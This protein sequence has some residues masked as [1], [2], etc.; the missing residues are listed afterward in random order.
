[1]SEETA[2]AASAAKLRVPAVRAERSTLLRREAAFLMLPLRSQQLGRHYGLPAGSQRAKVTIRK[3][4]ST[5][6]GMCVLAAKPN[7]SMPAATVLWG[8][9]LCL[10]LLSARFC[11]KLDVCKAEP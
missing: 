3:M 1:M 7:A 5:R 9:A 4:I 2:G 6:T 10:C 11:T 8:F